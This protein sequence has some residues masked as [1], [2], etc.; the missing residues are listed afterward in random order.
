MGYN[1]IKNID[2]VLKDQRANLIDLIE[3]SGYGQNDEDQEN[4]EK[5]LSKY[6]SNVS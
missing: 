1:E 4:F 2:Q 6:S 5:G 3:I